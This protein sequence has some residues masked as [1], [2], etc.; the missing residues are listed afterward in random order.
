MERVRQFLGCL[1]YCFSQGRTIRLGHIDVNDA[2]A[3]AI[4]KRTVAGMTGKIDKLV[5]KDKIIWFIVPVDD[6][7]GSRG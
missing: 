2:V 3:A 6:P 7:D 1:Y 5:R 4:K